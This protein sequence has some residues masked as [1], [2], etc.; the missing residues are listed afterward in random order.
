[1]ANALAAAHRIGA[2]GSGAVVLALGLAIAA[3]AWLSK[4]ID[5]RH[6]ALIEAPPGPGRD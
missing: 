4:W 5:R 3:A 6:P 1:M 2:D